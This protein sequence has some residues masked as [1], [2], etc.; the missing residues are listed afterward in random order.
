M[1]YLEKPE[2]FNSKFEIVSCF[3]EQD[4][5]FLILLRQDSKPQGNTWGVP[6]GKIE[7]DESASDAILRELEEE[8]GYRAT[9]NK[10]QLSNTVF[11]RYPEYDFVYHI[12]FLRL[13]SSHDVIIDPKA[14]KDFQWVSPQ[15]ALD[16]T[17]I[18]DLG[19]CIKLHYKL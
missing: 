14:H 3:L 13:T 17:L 11:V 15:E 6:A 16:K 5:K 7:N 10:L 8:T 9:R 18:P 19:A 1:I 12:Y 2:N 4:G